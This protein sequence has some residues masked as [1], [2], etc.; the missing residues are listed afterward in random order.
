[1]HYNSELKTAILVRQFRAPVLYVANQEETL[2][3]IAGILEENE[4]SQCARR[5]AMEEAGLELESLEHVFTG[6][7]MPGISTEQMHF[8]FAPYAGEAR[9]VFRGGVAAEYEDTQAVEIELGELVLRVDQNQLTDVKT[10]LL[11]QTMR[12]RKPELFAS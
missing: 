8:F 12:L 11:L 4:P 9:G 5:E 3:A 7:M 1:L 6:W 2:E 10:L